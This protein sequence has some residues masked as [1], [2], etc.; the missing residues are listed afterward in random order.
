MSFKKSLFQIRT[1]KLRRYYEE[2]HNE[3]D[4]KTK[5]ERKE[6]MLIEERENELEF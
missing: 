3:T 2:Y 4:Y 5:K 6:K 1:P